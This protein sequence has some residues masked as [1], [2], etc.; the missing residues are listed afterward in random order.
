MLPP[1]SVGADFHWH[2]EPL[3]DLSAVDVRFDA[4]GAPGRQLRLRDRGSTPGTN[5][6]KYCDGRPA[7][8][9]AVRVPDSGE[10][11]LRYR[12]ALPDA[13]A[14]ADF[15]LANPA[16]WMLA[17]RRRTADRW[18]ASVALADGMDVSLP[19]TPDG[20][21]YR[22]DPSPLSST[23][24]AV[25][26]RFPAFN[27]D[28][29]GA[30]LRVAYVGARRDSAL[31]P[32]LRAWLDSAAGAVATLYGRFPNPSPQVIIK[33]AT[34]TGS[35]PVP[36][37]MVKRNAGE[38]V[39]FF[40]DPT[41][42]LPALI[43]DWTA[44]HEFAHLLHPYIDGR[45]LSEGLATYLQNVLLARAEIYTEE[46]AWQ[47]LAAGFARGRLI[48]EPLKDL[49]NAASSSVAN[50]ARRGARRSLL[51]LSLASRACVANLFQGQ[52]AR[53]SSQP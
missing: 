31:V 43:D 16:E 53:Q 8:G 13:P 32:M 20:R 9:R 21:H 5:S 10:L 38:T 11:C 3:A 18:T 35:S 48:G 6:L 39:V 15:R 17:A 29:P 12:V 34:R 42:T 41:A 37:G 23:P 26:G 24:E 45:W 4:T 1:C 25:I 47:R 50:S 49:R 40:I 33:D 52:M 28:V 22:I 44:V 30:T 46:R 7:G 27:V 19:W 2:I 51:A 14:G 36:F